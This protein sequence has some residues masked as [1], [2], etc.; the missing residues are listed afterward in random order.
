MDLITVVTE[1]GIQVEKSKIYSVSGDI[2]ERC[3]AVLKWIAFQSMLF[4]LGGH[5][6]DQKVS[7]SI[8]GTCSLHAK[9]LN[10]NLL[11]MLW[12]VNGYVS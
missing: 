10:P 7:G 5:S 6:S 11:R 9:I 12:C 2:T 4:I 8:P 1:L 3:G